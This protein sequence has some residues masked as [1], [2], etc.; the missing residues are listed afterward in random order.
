MYILLINFTI[1]LLLEIF[2]IAFNLL[3]STEQLFLAHSKNLVQFRILIIIY[4][5]EKLV[6]YNPDI[7]GAIQLDV[8]SQVSDPVQP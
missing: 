5:C 1:C 3:F 8:Y 6:D 4:S 2:M 7:P